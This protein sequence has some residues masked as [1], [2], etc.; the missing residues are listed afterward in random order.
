MAAISARA[1]VLNAIGQ[2]LAIEVVTIQD[3]RPDEIRVRL[4]ATGICHT[5]LIMAGGA[6]KA[7]PPVVLGHEGAGIVESIGSNVTT[8]RVGDSVVLSFAHCGHCECCVEGAPSYCHE[9]TPRN[10]ACQRVDG[11]SAIV[12][13]KPVRSHF[14]GQSSFATYAVCDARNAVRV[15]NDVPLEL[16]GPL[17]CGFQTGAGAV[18]NTLGV[19][20]G[21]SIAVFGAGAVGLSAVMAAAAVG[22]STIIA[23]DRNP[24]RLELARELG[25]T[26]VV[27]FDGDYQLSRIQQIVPLGVRY[28]LDTTGVP[29]VVSAAI[30]ALAPRGI[31]GLVAGGPGATTPLPFNHMFVGGRTV[32]GIMEGDVVPASFIPMLIELYIQGRF[33]F[34]KLIRFYSL[35][36]INLA[37]AD[38]A[39]GEVVKPVIRF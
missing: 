24:S 23:I 16:L 31:C 6:L 14:F 10:F 37:F 21:A 20:A 13:E 27:L 38:A 8:H 29:A 33:P 26:H 17:G 2:P 22:A 15:R 36:E 18:I 30:E 3:P 28:A 19:G 5:D 7:A 12:A 1:A 34:D 39:S 25:A 32:R 9:F 4:V 35:D 11:T